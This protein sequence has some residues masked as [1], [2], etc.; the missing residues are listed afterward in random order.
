[1]IGLNIVFCSFVTLLKKNYTYFFERFLEQLFYFRRVKFLCVYSHM[2]K[3]K[4]YFKLELCCVTYNPD[5][6]CNSN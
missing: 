4:F 3:I 1:M 6:H 5:T 2:R